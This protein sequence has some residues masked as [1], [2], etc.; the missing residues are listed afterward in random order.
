M[1]TIIIRGAR[2]HNLKNLN[3]D[4][5]R[6][7]LIIISGLSGSGKSSLAFD[8]IFAE[9]QRRYIESL[10]SYARQFLGRLEKPEVDYIEGL[11]PAIAIEQKTTHRNP[12]STVGTVTEIYDYLRLLYARI[13]VPH[14]PECGRII[15][16]QSIDQI[17]D[18][19]LAYPRGSRIVLL[20][21]VVQAKKGEHQRVLE[22]AKQAGFLRVR[23][24]GKILSLDEPF[25]LDKNKKHTVEIVVDRILL[26]EGG[27]KR[28]ADSL[29]TALQVGEGKVTVL[30]IS[31]EGESEQFFSQK[32]ACPLCGISLPEIQPRL[33]S[34]N[35]PFGACL[36][37][38]G[39]G[40]TLEFDPDL[41]MPNRELSFNEGGIAP[42]NPDA[43]WNRSKFE[44]LAKHLHFSLD[45]P[46]KDLPEEVIQV[47]LYGTEEKV[48]VAYVNREG[49]GRFE[50]SA[51]F[52]GILSELRKRYLET[53]SDQIKSWLEQFMT[54]RPCPACKGTRL[55]PEALAITVGEKNIYQLSCLSVRESLDFFETLSL[56]STE[57]TIASQILKEIKSRLKFLLNVG[58]DYLTLHREASTLSGGEAQRI[59]LAT[60]I[61]S[62][63]VG[64]LY[65]LDE[66]TVGLHP[67]DTRRLIDTLLKLRDQGNTLIVV[68]HDAQT[69]LAADYIVDL[70]PGAGVH[71]GKVVA[72]GKPEEIF[73]HPESLTG[74]YLSGRL[75]IPVRNQARMGNGHALVLRG[76]RKHNLKNID[77]RIPL[78]KFVVITGVS[79][80]GKS[81]LLTD[82]LYPLLQ[83]A[84][85]TSAVTKV[86]EGKDYDTIEGVE[87]LDKV[88]LVDQ[89]PIGRTPRSNPA[90][91]TGLFGFIREIFASLPEARA[92]G[93]GPGRF[94]FNVPGGRCEHCKGDGTL[95]IEM[96]FLPDVFVTCEV[97]K[98]KRFN[99]ETL[100]IRF[101][102]KNIHEI[103][104]MTVEEAGQFFSFHP[105]LKEKLETLMS[106]GLGYIKLGQ[107]AVTL[108]GGEAQRIK[109]AYELSRKSTGTTL[110]ILDEPTT[111]LHFADVQMLLTVLN[112]LVDRG[113]TV[114]LIEHH[115]D[116]IKQADWIIDLGPEGGEEGGYIVAVGTPGEVARNFT[117]HTALQLRSVF[118]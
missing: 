67:R 95:R 33:F 76:A 75:S 69:L 20:A 49:T 39:L 51:P 26:E 12:R 21:P 97:C 57:L 2:E 45:T 15:R 85:N 102:G 5:P 70:G 65:I 36:E 22:G 24:D 8:T 25:H 68:E 113:N 37:C 94:S 63:L 77:V 114:L 66:P 55:K 105:R 9:G 79:G 82:L 107:P 34:F 62:S 115:L 3:L 71:G 87:F 112:R 116:V 19:I 42:F 74:K 81:S 103:L 84:I 13:G 111:G 6:D 90:T 46:L 64:V 47:I 18:T 50:Y 27:R 44:S 72:Q 4:L 23:I 89:E 108:S 96:H 1:D 28:L 41:L 29:E 93:Y 100:D 16:E 92:R 38:S 14:C 54:R 106:V 61:G 30:R 52:Q 104:E 78:G 109:L 17:L 88:I 117:S 32:S 48:N 56:N 80:S 43:Q 58:L 118:V 83:Q 53:T 101:K 7:K 99:Q 98:G 110:Y 35:S 73:H 91:Y 59:R 86:T 60:Q 11:S 40:I 31:D 10:S